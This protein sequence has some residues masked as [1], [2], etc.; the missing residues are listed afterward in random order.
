[1]FV[2]FQSPRVLPL[3]AARS[4]GCGLICTQTASLL[5]VGNTMFPGAGHVAKSPSKPG[6][7]RA[8]GQQGDGQPRTPP[9]RTVGL[10]EEQEALRSRGVGLREG[11]GTN[12]LLSSGCIWQPRAFFFMSL[13]A[14]THPVALFSLSLFWG[15]VTLTEQ[16]AS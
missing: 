9:H 8:V 2:M 1:M 14:S 15:E 10:Q 6:A 7:L 16:T 13:R 12:C 5:S 3:V 11:K 4:D